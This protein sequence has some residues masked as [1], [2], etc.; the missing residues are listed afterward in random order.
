MVNIIGS[1]NNQPLKIENKKN[2]DEKDKDEND[3]DQR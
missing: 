3:D 1:N 2:D